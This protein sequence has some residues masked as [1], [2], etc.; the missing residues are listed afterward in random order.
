METIECAER[1]TNGKPVLA[2]WIGKRSSSLAKYKV[3]APLLGARAN[4]DQ[5]DAGASQRRFAHTATLRATTS[6][7]SQDVGHQKGAVS[8]MKAAFLAVVMIFSSG[9]LCFSQGLAVRIPISKDIEAIQLSEHIYV[10]VSYAEIPPWGRVASNGLIYRSGG[11]ALLLDTPIND[12]LTQVLIGWVRDSLKVQVVGFVPNHWHSDCMGGLGYLHS[13]GIPSYAQVQTVSLART[14]HRPIPQH[15]FVDSL[16]LRVGGDLVVCRYFGAAH[17]VDN[18]VCWIPSQGVLFGGCMVKDLSSQTLGN[19]ADADLSA[20]PS[21][22]A[23]VLAAYPNVRVVVPGH[24]LIGGPDLLIH[25]QDLLAK[26][27]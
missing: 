11:E 17:S 23:R 12:S 26:H 2:R 9:D 18:I 6:S 25:T 15:S 16:H 27:K 3:L 14:N 22:I 8:G 20:W 4:D 1:L 7:S 13:I 5:F 21:T 24:G 10:H 19:T